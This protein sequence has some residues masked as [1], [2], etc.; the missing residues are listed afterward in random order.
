MID[1]ASVTTIVLNYQLPDDTV[2]A[3]TA[4]QRSTARGQRIIVL[5][6]READDAHRALSERLGPDVECLATGANLGYAAG[7]NVGVKR[8]LAAGAEFVWIVNPD[9]EVEPTTLERLLATAAEAPDAAT[10]GP[11]I[12]WPDGRRIWFDGGFVDESRYGTPSHRN[13]GLDATSTPATG[14]LEVD[15]VTGACLLV[16]SVVFEEVGLL[17]E[18][19][20]LYF[21]EVAFCR[22]VSRAG[23]RNL[24]E[25]RARI[26]HYKRSNEDLPKPYY[27]YYFTRSRLHF[28][29]EHF[30]VGPDQ[31]LPDL[32]ATFL[33]PWRAKVERLAPT[34]L[35]SFDAL[36][37]QAVADASAHVVG[38]STRVDDF[39]DPSEWIL[40]P[41]LGASQVKRLRRTLKQR[42]ARIAELEDEL[43]AV[44]QNP[45]ARALRALCRSRSKG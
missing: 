11:R 18:D 40:A 42:D 6:N 34:W 15:F 25:P 27:I 3:V 17:P 36:V 35:P 23:W 13:S 33:E 45:A 24:V 9:T 12:V 21:E 38:H 39:L 1:A 19:Y 37:E 5:D 16:R 2:R 31:V 20:F 32:S 44:R 43:R 28:A 30:G 26:V 8:A 14:P 7:N 41:A 29:R 4:L 22:R 10:F